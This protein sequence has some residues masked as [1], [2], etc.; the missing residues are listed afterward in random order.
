MGRLTHL[1]GSWPRATVDVRFR[2]EA[3]INKL[4]FR[5]LDIRQKFTLATVEMCLVS[6]TRLGTVLAKELLR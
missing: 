2:H 3:E 1:G 6:Y 5:S 4:L